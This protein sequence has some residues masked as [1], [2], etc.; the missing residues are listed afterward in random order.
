M[1]LAVT[2]QLVELHHGALVVE[3]GLDEGS[4]LFV[5]LPHAQEL[6]FECQLC[7]LGRISGNQAGYFGNIHRRL[8]WYGT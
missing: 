2:W 3:S 8:P 1:G 5:T 6:P 7:S 4:M